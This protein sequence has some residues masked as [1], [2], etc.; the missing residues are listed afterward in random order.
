MGKLSGKPVTPLYL[1]SSMVLL[2]W[3]QVTKNKLLPHRVRHPAQVP[4]K[5]FLIGGLLHVEVRLLLPV[6]R[7]IF[8]DVIGGVKVA[9]LLEVGNLHLPE[10]KILS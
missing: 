4:M 2:Y 7:C 6:I 9:D 10:Y 3:S 1:K 8:D 5:H